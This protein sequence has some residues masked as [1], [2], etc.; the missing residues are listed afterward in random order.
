MAVRDKLATEADK[1]ACVLRAPLDAAALLPPYGRMRVRQSVLC[2]ASTAS[3]SSECGVPS[4]RTM[5]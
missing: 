1:S 2:C 3:A 4:A 5:C